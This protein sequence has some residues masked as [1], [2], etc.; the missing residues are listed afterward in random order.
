MTFFELFSYFCDNHKSNHNEETSKGSSY[1][2]YEDL[3]IIL[4]LSEHMQISNKVFK[5]IEESKTIFRSF[6]SIKERYNEFLKNLNQ[7]ELQQ[8]ADH[9]K[10]N[11]CLGYLYFSSTEPRVLTSITLI[12]PKITHTQNFKRKGE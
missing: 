9:L 2:I 7:E 6:M 5:K 1:T 12:D 10:S 3:K 11:G 8:I 4:A